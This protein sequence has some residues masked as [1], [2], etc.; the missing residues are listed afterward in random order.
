LPMPLWKLCPAF[1]PFD[2]GAAERFRVGHEVGLRHR[3]EIARAEIA[4]DLDLMFDRPLP[5]RAEFAGAHCRFFVGEFHD[6]TGSKGVRSE[7][8]Y[9]VTPV[10]A[11]GASIAGVPPP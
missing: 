4:A 1:Q 10:I 8:Y 11:I 3:H 7:K 6:T 2:P 9:A 5:Q